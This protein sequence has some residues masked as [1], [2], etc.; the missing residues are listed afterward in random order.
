MSWFEEA[1][2]M[3][4]E[5][6]SYSEISRNLNINY[7]TLKSRF[8]RDLNREDI[9]GEEEITPEIAEFENYYVVALRRDPSK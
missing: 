7:N 1:Q 8:F 5:G 2:R 9:S 6:L 4:S 3:R